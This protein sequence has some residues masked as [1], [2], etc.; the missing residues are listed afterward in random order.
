MEQNTPY[1]LDT[2]L[3]ILFDFLFFSTANPDL[4]KYFLPIIYNKTKYTVKA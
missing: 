1:N 3:S 4:Q 2:F